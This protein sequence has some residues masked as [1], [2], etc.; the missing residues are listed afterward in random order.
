[1]NRSWN[2]RAWSLIP[3]SIHLLL[4]HSSSDPHTTLIPFVDRWWNERAV[5]GAEM[6]WEQ[7]VDRNKLEWESSMWIGAGM[8]KQYV[9]RSRNEKAV[10]GSEL[11]WKSSMWIEDGMRVVS[12]FDPHTTISFHLRSTYYSFIP[13]SIHIL[14]SHS[15]FDPHTTL[16]FHLRSTYYSHS[17]E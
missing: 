13:S 7:Y 2:E 17:I 11:E 1:M 14:L 4:S 5:C 10:C 15:I 9:D 6:K 8:R 12:I 3:S 16:S